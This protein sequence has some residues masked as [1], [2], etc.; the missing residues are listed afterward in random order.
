MKKELALDIQRKVLSNGLRTFAVTQ[1]GILSSHVVLGLRAGA[2]RE[3]AE[4]NG[5]AHFLEHMFFRGGI[6]YPTQEIISR[7]IEG[8]GGN[9]NAFTGYDKVYFVIGIPVNKFEVAM[10]VLSDMLFNAQLRTEDIDAE[11]GAV[12]QELARR[13]DDPSS[14]AWEEL[15][16]LMYGDTSLGRPIVGPRENLEKFS[17][18]DFVRFRQEMYNAR[19]AVLAF[20]GDLNVKSAYSLAEKYFSG[21]PR[22]SSYYGFPDEPIS[23]SANPEIVIKQKDFAQAIITL[24]VSAPAFHSNDRASAIVLDGILGSG[25]SSRLFQNVRTLKGLAYSVTS[26][27]GNGHDFGAFV[28][29]AGVSPTKTEEAIQAI[30]LEIRR[31]MDEPPSANELQCAKSF[32]AGNL[33]MSSDN[34][35]T[36]LGWL[37]GSELSYGKAVT[38]TDAIHDADNVSRKD[39]TRIAQKLFLPGGWKVSIVGPY[40]GS[41]ETIQDILHTTL[42]A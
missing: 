12:L 11:R 25:M 17:R 8:V 36:I 14:I 3:N 9:F 10:D 23:S 24:G 38:P 21:L 32:R 35:S 13:A 41:V 31:L 26:D 1:K 40:G 39:V 16:K 27:Y 2:R 37:V 19:E 30:A 7:A 6:R 29:S 28:C 34:V 4:T 15:H 33:A 5:I 42:I 18:P 20:S 22:S